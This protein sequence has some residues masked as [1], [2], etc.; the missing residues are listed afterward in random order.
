MRINTL[1]LATCSLA[2]SPVPRTYDV[3]KR[4]NMTSI[5]HDHPA[6]HPPPHPPTPH[7]RPTQ[8]ALRN[9][10]PVHGG[11]LQEQLGFS[12]RVDGSS[13]RGAARV[14]QR[15]GHTLRAVEGALRPTGCTANDGTRAERVINIATSL[16]FLAAGA[17]IMRYVVDVLLEDGSNT[18]TFAR[19]CD[20]RDTWV[21]CHVSC[22]Y[23]HTFH[24]SFASL[25]PFLLLPYPL[26]P[27]PLLST[28]SSA[29]AR[30]VPMVGALLWLGVLPQPI[31]HLQVQH[32]HGCAKPTT[33]ASAG[34][35]RV[36]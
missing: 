3:N 18:L 9:L 17:H 7:G 5:Q 8:G 16:P 31:M 13:A 22:P 35:P 36:C 19:F 34:Q 10:K 20:S 29:P 15:L 21:V 14:W 4:H 32:A 6:M 11:T 26:P 23:A 24:H 28:G 30:G 1:P 2:E 25:L 33:G 27:S 12:L